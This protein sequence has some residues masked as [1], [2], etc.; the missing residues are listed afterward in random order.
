MNN[1]PQRFPPTL[2][3]A[4]RCLQSRRVQPNRVRSERKQ[5]CGHGTRVRAETAF[6]PCCVG[7][8]VFSLCDSPYLTAAAA[9]VIATPDF[10]C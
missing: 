7:A 3:G 1:P 9:L 2:S 8:S 4:K 10:S 5:P 6:R